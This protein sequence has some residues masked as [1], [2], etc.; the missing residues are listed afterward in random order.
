MFISEAQMPEASEKRNINIVTTND[1]FF[2][3]TQNY[4]KLSMLW[5]Y[6]I[7]LLLLLLFVYI[8]QAADIFILLFSLWLSSNIFDC[9][10]VPPDPRDK[11]FLFRPALDRKPRCLGNRHSF[12]PQKSC[13]KSA[14]VTFA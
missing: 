8:P 7:S 5:I 12:L 9:L 6:F 14:C 2:T 4:F 13:E 3:S 1:Y 10:L 11:E